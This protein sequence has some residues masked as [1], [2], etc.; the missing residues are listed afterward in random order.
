M[1]KRLGSVDAARGPAG[2]P[3]CAMT[4]SRCT[5]TG[6]GFET[7]SNCTGVIVGHWSIIVGD[8]MSGDAVCVATAVGETSA[9]SVGEAI[10]WPTV[11]G[12][13]ARGAAVGASVLAALGR[14]DARCCE[15]LISFCGA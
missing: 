14:A 3:G 10:C 5:G 9:A 7:V 4:G 11:I 8:G 1:I 12:S 2:A 6:D 15:I 13:V